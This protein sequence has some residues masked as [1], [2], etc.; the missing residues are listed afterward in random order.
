MFKKIVISFLIITN[1]ITAAFC[2]RFHYRLGKYRQQLEHVRM[3]L[4]SAKNRESD[5]AES[6]R[7][8]GEV[9]DSSVNTLS[10]IRAQISEI[11]KNY[12]EM[13]NLLYSSRSND[14]NYDGDS[15]NEKI[16][17]E[18]KSEEKNPIQG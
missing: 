9:L 8:T 5:I 18:R 13:E 1:F 15:N 10:G 12:E 16:K 2:W 3:E 14:T 11:R 4:E 7:R 17:D 6:L